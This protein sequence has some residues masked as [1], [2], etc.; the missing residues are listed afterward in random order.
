MTAGESA[1]PSRSML[2]ALELRRRRIEPKSKNMEGETYLR[3]LWR[4]EVEIRRQASLIRTDERDWAIASFNTNT[5]PLTAAVE[6][7]RR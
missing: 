4:V 5:D 1:A 7:M 2:R 3:W 6:W